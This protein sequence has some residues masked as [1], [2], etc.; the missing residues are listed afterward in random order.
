ML[1]LD[2]NV[3]I[4]LREGRILLVE[5]LGKYMKEKVVDGLVEVIGYE[6]NFNDGK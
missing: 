5:V 2:K 6:N 3:W 4:L 1:G